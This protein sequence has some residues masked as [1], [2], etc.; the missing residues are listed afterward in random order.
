M[1]KRM[2]L[3]A[4]LLGGFCCAGLIALGL[5]GVS[6]YAVASGTRAIADLGQVRL[7]SID[8]LLR[9]NE[10][11]ESM[12]GSLRTLSIAG[13]QEDIRKRQYANLAEAQ[14]KCAAA[15]K[16]YESLPHTA[17]EK[18]LWKQFVPAWEAWRGQ[19]DKYLELCRRADAYA[20]SDPTDL[21]RQLEMFT[22]DHYKLAEKILHALRQKDTFEG[23]DD[24]T[25]CNCGKWL[26]TFKT[27]NADLARLTQAIAEPHQRFHQAIRQ[28]KALIAE[29]KS[30]EAY[31]AYDT[32]MAPAA[33]EVFQYFDDLRKVAGDSLAASVQAREL[34]LGAVTTDQRTVVDL[35]DQLQQVNRDS[36]TALAA[37]NRRQAALLQAG[38]LAVGLAAVFLTVV[39][40]LLMTRSIT[41]PLRAAFQGLKSC[42]TMELEETAA[43]LRR[44]IDSM[45]EGVS[46]VN[47]AAAQVASAS[48]QLAEGASEQAS[49]LEET[50]S[51]LEQMAAMARANAA[52]SKEAN[53]LAAQAHQAASAGEHTMAGINEA[54]DKISKIIK[55]IEEIAFQTNLLALNAAVEAARAGEH[56]KGFAVVAEEVRN[57][58]QRA[59]Q[60][61]RE[62]TGLIE[63]SVSKS[64]EGKNAIQAIVAGVAK[65]TE[66]INGISKASEEQAQGVEQVNTAVAQMDKVTQQNASASE[67]SAS[68]AEQLTAQAATTKGLVDELVMLVR[69][70][71]SAATTA[72]RSPSRRRAQA[73]PAS[74]DERKLSA[75]RAKREP[76]TPAPTATAEVAAT[77]S[78]TGPSGDELHE[79]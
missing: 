15:W 77:E 33:Q 42:S 68:A 32:Q 9:M 2:S 12:R 6:Y 23:G 39:L 56:G 55:V 29:G 44:I 5:A 69:G 1:F 78:A 49:A 73:T 21:A 4:K 19:V 74:Q 51:A 47:D 46:Q 40:G 58:A 14:E 60:A 43:T 3:R 13:L 8:S 45:A 50:S 7:P 70:A 57:L 59:A 24:H 22:K 71:A 65:V 72:S 37:E 75:R 48:Q 64:R 52:H 61:A 66:L 10:Q 53:D 11:T 54:S 63:E 26:A 30:E 28:I 35:L 16:T 18:E 67:E 27:D 38:T 62:T 34:L 17:K 36:A 79:F 31:A 41:R 25:A 76:R 20:I